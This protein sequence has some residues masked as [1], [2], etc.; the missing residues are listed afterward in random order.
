[1]TR[2][3]LYKSIS[4]I[5]PDFLEEAASYKVMKRHSWKRWGVIAACFRI[6]T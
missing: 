1:M 2:E 6:C 5:R 3:D 4:E